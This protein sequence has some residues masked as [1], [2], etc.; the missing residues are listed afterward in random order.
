[1]QHR[2]TDSRQVKTNNSA[3]RWYRRFAR[4]KH[5]DDFD[6]DDETAYNQQTIWLYHSNQM[7]VGVRHSAYE[8]V[9][10]PD[11]TMTNREQRSRSKRVN[12]KN[13]CQT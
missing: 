4:P 6:P 11:S 9:P 13:K 8:S 3:L 1:M 5:G 10:Q 12:D 2:L 7:N